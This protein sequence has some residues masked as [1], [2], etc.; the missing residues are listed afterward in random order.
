MTMAPLQAS[1]SRLS[2]P[3]IASLDTSPLA[4]RAT[5]S[6]VRD[7]MSLDPKRILTVSRQ[8]T[9]GVGGGVSVN[10]SSIKP[11]SI[12]AAIEKE[13]AKNLQVPVV[14][15][16]KLT[17]SDASTSSQEAKH[18]H[19][20]SD[21]DEVQINSHEAYQLMQR[22]KSEQFHKRIQQE[23]QNM[24]ARQQSRLQK[25][26]ALENIISASS[27]Q[28]RC[29]I[30]LINDYLARS[31]LENSNIS[32]GTSTG[33]GTIS[34]SPAHLV[35]D[36][37]S[38]SLQDT[39]NKLPVEALAAEL[40]ILKSQVAQLEKENH[41]RAGTIHSLRQQNQVMLQELHVA[42]TKKTEIEESYHKKISVL[43]RDRHELIYRLI[44]MEKR[45]VDAERTKEIMQSEIDSSRD[46][47]E[48]EPETSAESATSEQ[49]KEVEDETRATKD[50]NSEQMEISMLLQR[51]Q[52]FEHQREILEMTQEALEGSLM[53]A[54]ENRRQ[55][56]LSLAAVTE[57]LEI[58]KA[59]NEALSEELATVQEEADHLSGARN[60]LLEELDTTTTKLN[61]V[62]QHRNRLESE[63]ASLRESR[64]KNEKDL[65]EYMTLFN[66]QHKSIESVIHNLQEL[67]LLIK[68][69]ESKEKSDEK[70]VQEV[71]STD[72]EERSS[73]EEETLES[74]EETKAQ[75]LDSA[76]AQMDEMETSLSACLAG[77]TAKVQPPSE[78]NDCKDETM[79]KPSLSKF[80]N[81]IK[82]LFTVTRKADANV[83]VSHS[84]KG[85]FTVNRKADANV[86]VSASTGSNHGNSTCSQSNEPITEQI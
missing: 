3:H 27:S 13:N 58:V 5:T 68:S 55:V 6:A 14:F 46:T 84:I 30:S 16:T 34:S 51:I 70:D 48:P 65:A 82:G 2:S 54:N 57:E 85:L 39:T 63:N 4:P 59:D 50:S 21:D 38:E 47:T 81:S 74:S 75:W 12:A 7:N 66:A 1:P 60:L 23:K 73:D 25:V 76:L 53:E 78:G 11:R 61:D 83:I 72:S 17:Q 49:E 8:V 28:N 22:I 9:S 29:D 19:D 20:G 71:D 41:A 26:R 40:A 80:S 64:D 86:V 62:L 67:R 52:E 24:S 42:H 44:E 37:G 31:I 43:S 77:L 33:A 35:G 36:D 45:A 56:E 10:A 18:E 69:N 79:T 15:T 32:A